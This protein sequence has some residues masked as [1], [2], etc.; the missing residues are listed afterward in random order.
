MHTVDSISDKKKESESA[1]VCQYFMSLLKSKE[2]DMQM[3][4]NDEVK[5]KDHIFS[6]SS[7]FY[8]STVP[9]VLHLN[10]DVLK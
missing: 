1:V 9:W 7:F 4:A 6:L 3:S 2:L 8:S 5:K 10:N